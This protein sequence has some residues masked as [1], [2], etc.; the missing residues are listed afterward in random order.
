MITINLV[1]VGNL[2]EKF[3]V[4]AV[5]EYAK[6]LS[7]FCKLNI[8]EV[9]EQ[10]QLENP[11]VIIERE[12]NDILK[13]VEGY[14][15]AL[16]REGEELSSEK[17]AEFLN[18]VSLKASKITFVIGGSYGIS[19]AVK[20]RADKKLSFSKLTFPHNLFRV[21]FVEQLYRA[22]TI[23]AGKSYHK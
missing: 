15:V 11:E 16:D 10:N 19:D 8:I 6:R 9:K 13:K 14:L 4:D 12:G 22:F 23:I 18:E 20:T 21:M 5:N 2:K 1:C 3:S 7:A 17:F